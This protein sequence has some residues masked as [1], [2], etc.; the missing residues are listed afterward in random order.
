MFK[1]TQQMTKSAQPLSHEHTLASA[2]RPR[3]RPDEIWHCREYWTGDSRDGQ[4]TNGD[5]YHYFE[6]RGDGVIVK[7]L[8]Y[9]ETEDGEERT[10]EVP[11]LVG[12]NWYEF[13]GFDDDELLEDVPEHEFTYVEQLI[14][15]A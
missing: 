5:G 11:E 15:K 9:Y 3:R 4:Y 7:A 10:N 1:R 6:M 13:F 14:R 8:E 12:I 2:A